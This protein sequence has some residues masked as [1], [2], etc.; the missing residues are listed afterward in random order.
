MRHLSVILLVY[1]LSSLC[2][3]Y[4]HKLRPTIVTLNF[5]DAQVEL[6]V[7]TNAEALLAGIGAQHDNTDDAPQAQ[8]YKALRALPARELANRFKDF[9]QS[10]QQGLKLAVAGKPVDWAYQK[11]VVPELEDTRLARKS[12]IYFTASLPPQAGNVVWSSNP[13]YGDMVVNFVNPKGEK[14]SHWLVEGQASPAFKIQQL[15]P[16]RQWSSVFADYSELGF[17]H[18]LPMGMDH[19][20][21]VLGLFLLSRKASPLL[22]QVTAFTVAHSITL[23]LS[24]YGVI[25]LPAS[26]IEPLIALS[27]A[28]VGMENLLTKELKPW[29]VLVVFVFGLLHGMGFAEVLFELG[30]PENEFVTALIAFN[31]GVEGGQL[32]VILL[33]FCAVFWLRRYDDLYR[34][35]VVIP[36]SLGITVMGLFWVW[37][38]VSF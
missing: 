11:I 5:S 9:A 35:L 29:R 17:L 32:A 6:I 21:F 34:R 12:Q 4:A 26:I 8:Q 38:R 15:S 30:L 28:Y 33:A 14:V 18:I 24:V 22:W 1:L 36:G 7:E 23:A 37:Q 10:Y 16:K 20:L 19:I 27:I 25:S 13:L 3:V 31:L 2:T